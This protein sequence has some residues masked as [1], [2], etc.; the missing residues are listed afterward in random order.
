VGS[1]AG[2]DYLEKRKFLASD[3]I[4]IP[5]RPVRSLVTTQATLTR[6]EKTRNYEFCPYT[7]LSSFLSPPP[8]WAHSYPS[9][10]GSR[11]PSTYICSAV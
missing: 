3:V 7:N 6:L 4:Q 1:T 10:P 11:V 2:L 9:S 8:S 5:D